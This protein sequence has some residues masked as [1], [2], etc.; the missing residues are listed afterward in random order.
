M[1]LSPVTKA[2]EESWSYLRNLVMSEIFDFLA[3]GQPVYRESLN[4]TENVTDTTILDSDSE[5]VAAIKELFEARIRPSVQEDGG[6]IFYVGFNE[7][8]G[9]VQLRLAG[10]CVGCPSSSVTLRN[11]VENMLKHYI[12][13]VKGIEELPQIDVNEEDNKLSFAPH[14]DAQADIKSS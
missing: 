2:N 3:S 11:G 6:D 5:I 4:P 13:E 1:L 8:T 12:P 7:D 10:S 14:T 9:I